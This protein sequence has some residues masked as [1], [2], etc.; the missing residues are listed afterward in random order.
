MATNDA[1][2]TCHSDGCENAGIAIPVPIHYKDE[3]SGETRRVDFVACGVCGNDIDDI[4]E[5]SNESE[6]ATA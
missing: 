3:E 6:P 4:K 1:T 2:A 5:T